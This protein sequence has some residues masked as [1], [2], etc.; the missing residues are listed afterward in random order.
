MAENYNIAQ[1]CFPKRKQ[2][3]VID[4]FLNSLGNFS[5]FKTIVQ[6]LERKNELEELDDKFNSKSRHRYMLIIDGGKLK[7][8]DFVHF[9]SLFALSTSSSV[10]LDVNLTRVPLLNHFN[11]SDN[12]KKFKTPK[13]LVLGPDLALLAGLAMELSQ[14][15][16]GN[17]KSS[18]FS[19]EDLFS[20]RLGTEFARFVRRRKILNNKDSFTKMF[21]DF[22]LPYKPQQVPANITNMSCKDIEKYYSGKF[23]LAKELLIIIERNTQP[24]IIRTLRFGYPEIK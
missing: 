15:Y 17:Q 21:E 20:N 23:S 8:V 18:S 3:P 7:I 1:T 19:P 12:K 14:Q 13:L 2:S 6:D 11:S 16:I 24:L 10:D 4:K 9:F 5:D 22:F